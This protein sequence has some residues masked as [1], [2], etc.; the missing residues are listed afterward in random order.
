MSVVIEVNLRIPSLTVRT[1]GEPDHIVNNTAV[2]FLKTMTVPAVPKVQALMDVTVQPD[3]TLRCAVTRAEWS[4]GRDMFIVSCRYANRA[5]S[6][7]EY[8]ALRR[9]PDWRRNEL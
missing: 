6:A 2:R 1:V 4:D 8:L 9:D 7:N 3:I 5:I